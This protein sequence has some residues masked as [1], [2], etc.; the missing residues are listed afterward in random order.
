MVERQC[1]A[2]PPKAEKAAFEYFFLPQPFSKTVISPTFSRFFLCGAS[3]L[4]SAN[5]EALA[6]ETRIEEA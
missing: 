5:H 6:E 1:H 3:L 2:F 4:V